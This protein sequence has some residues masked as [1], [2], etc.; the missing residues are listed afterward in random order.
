MIGV[1]HRGV[2]KEAQAI[3]ELLWSTEFFEKD[4]SQNK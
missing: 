1:I 4:T 3:E 2:Q